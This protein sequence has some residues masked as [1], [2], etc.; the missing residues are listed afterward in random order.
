MVGKKEKRAIEGLVGHM[1]IVTKCTKHL[2][3]AY[4][5]YTEGDGEDFIKK[6]SGM[7]EI[8]K[9][10]DEARRQVELSIHSGA[11]MPLHREDYLNLAETIDMVA[12]ESVS[13]INILQLTGVEIP[14]SIKDRIDDMIED[15]KKCVDT[16][17]KC[18][19]ACVSKRKKATAIAREVE[20]LEEAIDEKEFNL[21]SDIYKMKID[22]YEKIL[23]NDLVEKLG[24]I[25]DTA[26]DASDLIVILISKRG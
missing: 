18:L 8:E 26:E 7:R 24:D 12:D 15:T 16:L 4:R 25:S 21:R 10:A 17:K 14:G 13:A 9:E 6:A 3:I 22:G 19:S 1:D 20:K 23:L 2:S 11:F 5:A